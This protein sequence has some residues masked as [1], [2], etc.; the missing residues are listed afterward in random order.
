MCCYW[1]V[2]VTTAAKHA[3]VVFAW[4]SAH[5]VYTTLAQWV[6][7]VNTI[8]MVSTLTTSILNWVWRSY[9]TDT[10]VHYNL[11]CRSSNYR[12]LLFMSNFLIAVE[13]TTVPVRFQCSDDKVYHILWTELLQ[14]DSEIPFQEYEYVK[15]GVWVLVPWQEDDSERLQ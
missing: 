10:F 4:S 11:F 8:I 15:V 2:S 6:K 7:S 13:N 9:I 14:V 5:A 1:S 12:T 3:A